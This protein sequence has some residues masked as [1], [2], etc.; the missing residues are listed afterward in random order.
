[1]SVRRL[2]QEIKDVLDEYSQS[3]DMKCKLLTGRRVTLVE[4]L[5]KFCIVLKLFMYM[6]MIHIFFFFFADKVK[7]IQEKLEEFIQAL[8]K[9]K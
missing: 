9:E 3:H 2:H 7:Q 5:S 1:M 4:E 6:Y 8:N